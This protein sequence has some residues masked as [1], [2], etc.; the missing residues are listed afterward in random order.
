MVYSIDKRLI[1]AV[2]VA[3]LSLQYAYAADTLS[4]ENCRNLPV[5]CRYLQPYTSNLTLEQQKELIITLLMDKTSSPYHS[6]AED[7]NKKLVFEAAPENTSIAESET[8]RSTWVKIAA[9]SPSVKTSKNIVGNQ[10]TVMTVFGFKA[11][12]PANYGEQNS[13]S[14]GGSQGRNE[15]GD[16][17]TMYTSNKAN[18]NLQIYKNGQM[19]GA[20]KLTKFNSSDVNNFEAVLTVT[21]NM[22]I[23]HYKWN[24]GDCCKKQCGQ[25]GCTC[26]AYEDVCRF[27]SDDEIS[28]TLTVRDDF[29]AYKEGVIQTMEPELLVSVSNKPMTAMMSL[30]TENLE[31]FELKLKDQVLKKKFIEYGLNYT[32]PPMNVLHVTANN[33]KGW[34]TNNVKLVAVNDKNGNETF[35]FVTDGAN[36]GSCELT[37][38][39]YFNTTVK[40]CSIKMLPET[41]IRLITDKWSYGVNQTIS[42]KIELLAGSVPVSSYVYIQYGNQR[43]NVF[44]DKEDIITLNPELEYNLIT[45]SMDGE[46]ISSAS[47][48][49]LISVTDKKELIEAFR[50]VIFAAF[51]VLGSLFGIKQLRKLF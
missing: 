13:G 45:V 21:N 36:I 43:K 22:K 7:W 12:K 25:S 26:I 9:V 29:V 47:T 18:A 8:I 1:I 39:S 2:L 33:K 3:L 15:Y 34:F 17:K 5:S 37:L 14:C 35:S 38:R 48:S 46:G 28:D 4:I 23:K 6:L 20:E 27:D 44:I 31:S 41:E 40:K 16:C 50:V 30:P 42:L 19:I 32:L 49:A 11:E 51:I 10:G 24:R